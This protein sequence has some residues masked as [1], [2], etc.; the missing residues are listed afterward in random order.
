M[1]HDNSLDVWA[2]FK[3]PKSTE[4]YEKYPI[5]FSGCETVSKSWN[6]MEGQ[7]WILDVFFLGSYKTWEE[8][9]LQVVKINGEEHSSRM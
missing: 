1:K 9:D 5:V 3:G 7:E 4:D 2:R 8:E 6:G